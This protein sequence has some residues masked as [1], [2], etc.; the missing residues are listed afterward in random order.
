MKRHRISGIGAA[1]ASALLALVFGVSSGSAQPTAGEPAVAAEQV[2]VVLQR[3]TIGYTPGHVVAGRMT[4]VVHN[5]RKQTTTFI[6]A[7]HNGGMLTLPSYSGMPFIPR[8][9]IVGHLTRLSP[10]SERRLTLILVHGNY[11][12]LTSKGTLGGDSPILVDSAV[13]FAVS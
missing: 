13:R 5:G 12:V 8:E 11:A 6:I 7:R 2:N 1:C 10:G 4:L 9:E 3:G